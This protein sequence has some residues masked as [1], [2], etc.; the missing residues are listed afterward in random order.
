MVK[1]ATFVLIPG[2]VPNNAALPDMTDAARSAICLCQ[3]LIGC[4]GIAAPAIP[5]TGLMKLWGESRGNGRPRLCMH[6]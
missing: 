6:S 2:A 1:F 3:L 5:E 4:A